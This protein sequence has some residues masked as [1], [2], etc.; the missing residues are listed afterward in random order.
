MPIRDFPF[1]TPWP[2]GPPNVWLPIR[3]INPSSAA[4]QDTYGLID[5][6][7]SRCTIPGFIAEAIGYQIDK[8]TPTPCHT[9]SGDDVSYEHN[10][11]IKIFNLTGDCVYTI[12]PAQMRV[13][14]KL[15][16][17]LR[18]VQELLGKFHLHVD[19]P[20]QIFSVKTSL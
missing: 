9:G 7:A 8:G 16:Y 15:P 12:D 4:Y 14:K 19:Y 5:T 1:L 3:V 17:V 2:G 20:K 18:G 10:I 13:M 11:S 6:G